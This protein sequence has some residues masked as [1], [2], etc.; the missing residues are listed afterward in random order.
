[1]FQDDDEAHLL[2][3]SSVN[4]L[5]T[6]IS[7]AE[8]QVLNR[9]RKINNCAHTLVRKV[10]RQMTSPFNLLLFSGAGFII[11]ELTKCQP[12]KSTAK[13]DN[14]LNI[15]PSPLRMASSLISS[16]QILYKALPMVCMVKTFF[17]SDMSTKHTKKN[18]SSDTRAWRT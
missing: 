8:R 9:Q 18:S 13:S 12:A 7:A 1:M 2:N 4:S 15:V 3:R 6:Q 11:G 17:Q 16:I 14:M 10:E 5:A